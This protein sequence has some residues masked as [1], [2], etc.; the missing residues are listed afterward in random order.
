MVLMSGDFLIISLD[1]DFDDGGIVI[2]DKLGVKYVD[3]EKC[4]KNVK[5]E[6]FGFIMKCKN[7]LR[8]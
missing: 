8:R 7:I 5:G 3:I 6:V 4:V 1:D 2:V